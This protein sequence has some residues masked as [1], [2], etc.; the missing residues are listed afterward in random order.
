M[1][2]RRMARLYRAGCLRR[3]PAVSWRWFGLGRLHLLIAGLKREESHVTWTDT[4]GAN[5]TYPINC[6]DWYGAFAF[7]VW[8]GGRLPTEAEWEYPCKASQYPPDHCSPG[9]GE[10]NG[11][12]ADDYGQ[13][14]VVPMTEQV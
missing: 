14:S 5:E 9:P 3:R 11:G 10:P 1:R 4:P 13:L 2:S 7:C 12:F 6:V 8:D